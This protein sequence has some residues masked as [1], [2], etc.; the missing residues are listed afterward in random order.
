[1]IF[2]L[3]FVF[4]E[5][6]FLCVALAVL[7]L[8]VDQAGLELRNP[9]ASASASQSA[10]ITGVLHHRQQEAVLKKKK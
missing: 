4:V 3:F 7:E 5:T 10:G 6:G 1:M 8:T 9:P 2:F